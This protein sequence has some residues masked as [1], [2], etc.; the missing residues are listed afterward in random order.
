MNISSTSYVRYTLTGKLESVY[1][2][3]HNLYSDA[4]LNTKSFRS[5]NLLFDLSKPVSLQ[6][7]VSYD[8][9]T[10]LII[11]DNHNKPRLI[12]TYFAPTENDSFQLTPHIGDNNTNVYKEDNLDLN[13]SLYKLSYRIPK[14]KLES[15]RPGGQLLVGGYVF[16]IKASDEDGNTTDILAESGV[17]SI[18]TSTGG[19][20]NMR[21]NKL[22][23]LEI[24][25]IDTEYS[26]LRIYY[27]RS[28]SNIHESASTTCHLI[29]HL[30]PLTLDNTS[31]KARII[32]TGL[33]NVIN[34]EES[35]LNTR[36]NINDYVRSQAVV[37]SR[38]FLGNG[39]NTYADY[40][41]LRDLSRR[42]VPQLNVFE[43]FKDKFYS[44]PINTYNYTGYHP[45]EIYRF[46]IVYIYAN[47]STSNVFN[48]CGVNDLNTDNIN[49]NNFDIVTGTTKEEK[50]LDL[51]KY[52][53]SRY[54]QEDQ[55]NDY[56]PVVSYTVGEFISGNTLEQYNTKG[57]CYLNPKQDNVKNIYGIK[58]NIPPY[59]KKKLKQLGIIGYFFVRQKRIPL[60]LCECVTTKICSN[61]HTP[62]IPKKDGYEFESYTNKNCK[63]TQD[64]KKRLRNCGTYRTYKLRDDGIYGY[65]DNTDSLQ[66]NSWAGICPDYELNQ[67]YYNNLFTG[68]KFQIKSLEDIEW[69]QSGS[70]S[71][72]R[73]REA[74]HNTYIPA[75]SLI[76]SKI[77]G[78]E[79]GVSLLSI[80]TDKSNKTYEFSS[81]VGEAS[82]KW[83]WK[84]VASDFARAENEN[85][86]A[87][88]F[89]IQIKK[90]DQGNIVYDKGIDERL[91]WMSKDT[92]PNNQIRG[93]FG[94]YLGIYSET[95][96]KSKRY[97]IY[98]ENFTIDSIDTYLKVRMLNKGSYYAIGDRCSIDDDIVIQYRGDCFIS[99]FAH[100]LNRNFQDPNAPNNDIIIQPEGTQF[101]TLLY[102]KKTV[103]NKDDEDDQYSSNF[104]EGD[105]ISIQKDTES[106]RNFG[107]DENMSYGKSCN[108]G[109][110]NAVNIGTWVQ[111][112]IRTDHN[113]DMR[114][115][116]HT[117]ATE[118][119]Q[120]GSWR[121]S[122]PQHSL[123]YGGS[124][125]FP[126]S[127]AYNFGLS[128]SGGVRQ[129]QCIENDSYDNV[130]YKNRIFY[131]NID[132]TSYFVNGFRTF[133]SNQYRDYDT[134]YG[135]ITKLVSWYG[136]LLAIFEYGICLIPINER[137]ASGEGA[138]GNLYINTNNVLPDT[139]KV[140]SPI[141]GT[142]W[143]ESVI[144][145]PHYVY[146]VD[147]KAKKIWRTDG[148]E[149]VIISDFKIQ[150]FLNDNLN[151][152]SLQPL[153]GRIILKGHYIQ[154]KGDVIFTLYKYNDSDS[155][156]NE[157]W[158]I[159][160]NENSNLWTTMYSWIPS[161]TANLRT[162]LV[163]FNYEDT[164]DIYDSYYM[165]SILDNL[166]KKYNTD[167]LLPQYQNIYD[168]LIKSNTVYGTVEIEQTISQN[169][170]FIYGTITKDKYNINISGEYAIAPKYDPES[171]KK[172]TDGNSIY[173]NNLNNY[174][175]KNKYT[176]SDKAKLLIL[177]LYKNHN[178]F[179]GTTQSLFN[180]TN[181]EFINYGTDTI[182][183]ISA[184][185]LEKGASIP[186]ELNTIYFQNNCLY[187]KAEDLYY[188]LKI[189]GFGP[190]QNI[191]KHGFADFIG[192]TERIKPT[193][194]FGKIYPF[195][196]EYVTIDDPNTNKLFE[197]IKLLSNKV[198][199]ESLH[200]EI[201]GE[202]YDFS[203]DKLNAYYRQEN[204][205]ELWHKAYISKDYAIK[206]DPYYKELLPQ[207]HQKYLYNYSGEKET[208]ATSTPYL[209]GDNKQEFYEQNAIYRNKEDKAL[210]NKSF[211]PWYYYCRVHNPN[212][213]E[214]YYYQAIV[215]NK[216][217]DGLGG[218]EL[219]WDRRL[220][221]FKIAVHS[222]AVDIDGPGGIIR[223]NMKYYDNFWKITI[224]TILFKEK[225]ETAW[226]IIEYNE[227]S[228]DL[229][230]PEKIIIPK[231]K[232][233]KPPLVPL[234]A[235]TIQDDISGNMIEINKIDSIA[236]T[237]DLTDISFDYDTNS[238]GERQEAKLQD[239]YMKVR[240]RYSGKDKVL[241]Q[242]VKTYYNTTY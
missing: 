86:I 42:I 76:N 130:Y 21:S 198:M 163:S 118:K 154:Y 111:F 23:S 132:I 141:Y 232:Y 64:Y 165:Q 33:E 71:G 183:S 98:P 31:K 171:D 137:V 24:T 207:I 105:I 219:I 26:H 18:T 233:P 100:R 116:D 205:K 93:L 27:S 50:D 142:Q 37:N 235:P 139:P 196:V 51:L 91:Q 216:N 177:Y 182:D 151:L 104:I 54:F 153:I 122:Y 5:K 70:M 170:D 81:K 34:I 95:D 67:Y 144:Q 174:V 146:G 226:P 186:F 97:V 11:N 1:R 128:V 9:S 238:W 202:G 145:T 203:D 45:Y 160:W 36:Y 124:Y 148:N 194:W 215:K 184:T 189:I 88:L 190:S 12:N 197:N 162:A 48:T 96:L 90:D 188:K 80:G 109:D 175:L 217:Y 19:Y 180:N 8:N 66:E 237:M 211:I 125:K 135:A 101:P 113:Y 14:I 119:L 35:E 159:C 13:T 89:N 123:Y 176:L 192:Q 15:I 161:Y 214:S 224:P 210:Y 222:K 157:L 167:I 22:I 62:A 140:L 4:E 3:L 84:G 236:K 57:V 195:E 218:T 212:D 6:T 117:N 200:Y 227:D 49:I 150:S 87:T 20:G 126:D 204:L 191:Y 2:P 129:Y 29:D 220:N 164:K 85:L 230:S 60:K 114:S 73:L 234:I 69:P 103:D 206:Y 7:Q 108:V 78:V 30:Y 240:I 82:D 158:N 16:Y 79:D 43:G 213:I 40:E 72:N 17:I 138:G 59:V 187:Y 201:I 56:A 223:G 83:S 147:T 133:I 110:L 208:L 25:N 55:V 241:L 32:I 38:L 131:S 99:T 112:L 92:C 61:T 231:G 152:H 10:N 39:T 179:S 221:D 106:K 242:A 28:T 134:S 52:N 115:E 228:I 74:T 127:T 225:N 77:V 75:N 65:E 53:S 181:I 239:R 121:T 47:N 178:K 193:Q 149:V 229:N 156:K 199:P 102:V 63:L 173:E 209:E 172:D 46:G 185:E 166:L 168:R 120:M 143:E 136:N 68:S 169:S 155:N 58:F 41:M 94:P 107:E 44:D